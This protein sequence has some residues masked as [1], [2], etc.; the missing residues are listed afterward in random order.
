[1]NGSVGDLSISGASAGDLRGYLQAVKNRWWLIALMVVVAVGTV[2]TRQSNLPTTY[3]TTALMLVTTPTFIDPA[4]AGGVD[5][6]ARATIPVVTSDIVQLISSRAIASRVA[7]RLDLSGPAEVQAA[8]T[9]T[10]LRGT[11]FLQVSASA[12]NP[13]HAA[14]LANTSAEELI[15]YFRET[16]RANVSESRRFVEEQLALTRSRLDA[17]ERAI[18]SFKEARQ[19]PSLAAVTS[20]GMSEFATGQAALDAATTSLREIDAR[21]TASRARVEREAP[22]VVTSQSMTAN[23]VWRQVQTRLVELEI[24]RLTLSQIYT[25]EHPRMD[26]IV[27]EINELQKRLTTEART[28]VGEEVMTSNPI[29]ARLLADMVTQE[30]DHAA[31]AARVEALQTMQRRRQAA[32]MIIPSAEREYN[33][34]VRDQRVVENNYMMLSGRYQD[35]LIRENQAGFFP[36]GLQLIEPATVPA[37]ARTS[38]VPITA[39]GA[40]LVA[41]LLGVMAALMLEAFDDRVRSSQDAE[42]TLGVPV[43]AQVPTYGRARANIAPAVFAAVLLMVLVAAV[44]V[45]TIYRGQGA[46]VRGASTRQWIGASA[47]TW[48]VTRVGLNQPATPGQ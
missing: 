36:A 43:L 13:E 39:A 38:S 31:V 24:Q 25:P 14:N 12:R 18:Q 47:V 20:Q 44:A 32:V 27:R 16:N 19:M 5:P 23:P 42:R 17:S 7:K 8:I 11:S 29:R 40:G 21:L 34:L 46:A 1:M 37:N 2:V 26:L 10:P 6:G 48:V 22:V 41:L 15:A 3:Q 28:A 33:K 45:A 9:A 30:V 4:A 35:L